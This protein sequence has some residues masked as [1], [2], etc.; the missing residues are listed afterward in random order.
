MGA[1]IRPEV[2][3]IMKAIFSAVM[4]CAAMMRSPS[5]SREGSSRTMMNSPLPRNDVSWD[6]GVVGEGE[7]RGAYGMR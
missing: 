7:G 4:S 6:C 1:Q 2:W 5:F 3:R